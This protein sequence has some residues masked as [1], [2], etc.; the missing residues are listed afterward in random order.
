MTCTTGLFQIIAVALASSAVVLQLAAVAGNSWY[1]FTWSDSGSDLS[2]HYGLFTQ[3]VRSTSSDDVNCIKCKQLNDEFDNTNKYCQEPDGSGPT[4][5]EML[6]AIRGTMALSLMTILVA[7]GNLAVVLA[8]VCDKIQSAVPAFITCILTGA[9]AIGTFVVFYTYMNN[10]C[11]LTYCERMERMLA[12]THDITC[13]AS[14]GP[15]LEMG[16]FA[17]AFAAAVFLALVNRSRA[18]HAREKQL[19]TAQQP[20]V[21]P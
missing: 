19:A 14:W 18:R 17:V 15:Y 3:C 21:N 4:N 6:P 9:G 8:F 16:S 20:M 11:P 10:K 1:V 2:A 7:V 12:G 5:E 13:V